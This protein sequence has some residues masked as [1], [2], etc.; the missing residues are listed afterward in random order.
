V[1][2]LTK[3]YLVKKVWA[4]FPVIVKSKWPP[5]PRLRGLGGQNRSYRW[6]VQS[7]RIRHNGADIKGRIEIRMPFRQ[8]IEALG[9]RAEWE[10]IGGQSVRWLV[11][12]ACLM[13]GP[14]SM[15]HVAPQIGIPLVLGTIVFWFWWSAG[16]I[17]INMNLL[18][19]P[20]IILVI[21]VNLMS[22]VSMVKILLIPTSN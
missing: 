7:C 22:L 2:F 12:F 20:L 21:I 8:I 5:N 4:K 14:L 10:S 11:F 18:N 1:S 17:R 15:S 16:F 13:A 3:F 19:G 6:A 9:A